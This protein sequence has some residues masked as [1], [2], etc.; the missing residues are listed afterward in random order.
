MTRVKIC[1]VN[2][3][4][5]FDA[6][7]DAGA[8]WIG[9]VFLDR[10]PRFVTP[11][12]AAQLSARRAGG[13]ARVGL[14]VD[15]SDSEIAA[16]IAALKLDVLQL[17][18]PV[19]RTADV[20]KRFSVPVW[21]SCAVSVAADLPKN[22][23]GAAALVIEAPVGGARPGGCGISL[24]WTIVRGVASEIRLGAGGRADAAQCGAGDGGDGCDGG[25]CIVGRRDFA[26]RE[27][28]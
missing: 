11:A 25:G 14:F 28:G 8:D 26:R 27:I 17:Y 9:F 22:A 21:R 13:P 19:A 10:S 24:D 3:A 12:I 4:E 5:A 23:G 18:A 15:P 1:G 2:S 6:A 20:A 16:A 7:S